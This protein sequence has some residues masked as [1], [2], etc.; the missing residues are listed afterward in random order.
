MILA[1]PRLILDGDPHKAL[2][3]FSSDRARMVLLIGYRF[4]FL[5]ARALT[6][7]S[8]DQEALSSLWTWTAHELNITAKAT[9]R[10]KKDFFINI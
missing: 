6:S 2:A 7:S 5:L 10:N 4:P 1:W 8:P 9:Q 3:L